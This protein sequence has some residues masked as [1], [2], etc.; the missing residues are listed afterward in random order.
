MLTPLFFS[1]W[2]CRM[3]V[4]W[5]EREHEAAYEAVVAD[6]VVMATL[7]QCGLVKL[8]L[9]PFMH[10]QPRLLNALVEYWHPDAEAFMIEGK[11]LTPTTEDIYFLTGLSRRGETVD[12]HTFPTGERKVEELIVEYCVAGTN[13]RTSWIPVNS[14]INIRLQTILSLIGWITGSTAHHKATRA[15]LN[16]ALWCLDGHIFDWSTTLLEAMRRQ[17]TDCRE[18]T[19]RNFGFGTILCS[20]FFERVPCFSPRMTV[21]GHLAT[22]PAVCRW[23]ALLP[24]Q[25]GGRTVESFNDDFFAWLSRQIPMIE[26]YPYAGID[27][28]RDPEMPVPPG[29][30]LG[31]IGKSPLVLFFFLF[32]YV[33]F[34]SFWIYIMFLDDRAF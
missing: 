25:G 24:R 22:F 5:R 32:A 9:C 28:S 26:D 12:L 14:I 23:S 2:F 33:I 17:L 27:F 21:R 11:S 13:T 20:F 1:L 10:A 30:A 19:H 8:F 6:P 15:H 34:M 7:T 29:E 16:C 18:R 3:Y 31:E 4:H